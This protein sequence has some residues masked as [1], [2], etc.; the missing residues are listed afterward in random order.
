MNKVRCI[1]VAGFQIEKKNRQ[2]LWG[3]GALVAI[4][5]WS[6]AIFA[7]TS[8][9]SEQLAS[10]DPNEEIVVKV[11]FS[12]IRVAQQISK[13]YEPRESKY[14]SGFIVLQ[15]SAEEIER[16]LSI[17]DRLNVIVELD[18]TATETE[19]LKALGI[20]L[21]KK[22][23]GLLQSREQSSTLT[24]RT[25]SS[26][27]SFVGI[28]GFACYRTVEETYATAEDIVL[29]HP[30]LATWSDVG[31]S[32]EKVN[33]FGGYDLN[34]LRLTNLSIVGPK[35]TIFITSSIHAREYTTAELM[36]RFA[37]QL[38]S[39]YGVDADTTWILDH[40]DIRLMLVANPDGRKQAETGLLWRK[41]VNQNYC[42]ATSNN[43][44][45]DLNR[46][47]SF[48]WNCCNGSSTNQCSQTYHGAFAAS[49]PETQ[50]VISQLSSIFP[51]VRGPGVNDPAPLDTSGMYLDIHSS[52]R[53]IL[54]PWGFT[55]NPAP[56]GTQLQT[57]GRKLAFFNG[58]T[59]QQSIGLYPTDGT[60]TSY[61]YGELGLPSYTY[62]LGTEFFESCGYFENT[63]LPDNLPSLKYALKTV[64][65]PYLLP[66]GP[67]GYGIGLSPDAPAGV[68][69]GSIVDLTVTYDDTRYNN[70]NGAE[71]SQSIAEVEYYIDVPPWEPG[72]ETFAVAMNP[73]DGVF[74]SSIEVA[75]VSI[76]TTLLS[77][78]RHTIYT[79]ARDTAGNWGV[80][81]AAFLTID[82]NA[83]L[84]TVL[85]NDDFEND[86]G[87]VTNPNATDTATTGQW[88]RANPEQTTT[89]GGVQQLGTANSGSFNLVTGPLAGASV[90][91]ND[92]D[93]G[94]TSIRSP[95]IVIPGNATDVQ[96]SFYAYLAHTS[97]ATIDDF[98][99]VS[100][101]GSSS[102]T[103]Q[104][105]EELGS[106]D[107]DNGAWAENSV[108]LDTF[109]GET[110]YMLVEAADAGS[111]SLV[112]AGV[113]DVSISAVVLTG[114]N[115]A[116]TVEA[117][118]DQT[119]TLPAVAT[120]D[121]AV[122]DDGLPN[123][124]GAVSTTWSAVSG[125]G[126]ATFSDPSSTTT[127]VSFDVAGVYVLRLS[128]SD[129]V[130]SNFDEVVVTVSDAPPVN[131][132]PNVNAGSDLAVALPSSLILD[133]SVED[134]GL[135]NPPAS[136]TTTWSVVSGPGS[137]SFANASVVDTSATFS[138]V[139]VYVLRLSATD[140][141]LSSEDDMQVVVTSP[142]ATCPAG[143]IN[144][145]Q[146]SLESYSNQDLS[147]GASAAV[148]GSSITLTGNAWKRSTQSFD[149]TSNT[150]IKFDYASTSQGEIHG[151][152]FDL[153]QTLNND[154]RLFQFWGTQNWTGGGAINYSP[155]YGGNGAFQSYSIPV[156]NFYSGNSFRLVFVNDKDSGAANNEGI[157]QC[158]QIVEE[159]PQGSC[160]VEESF[161]GGLGGW[162]NTA[163]STCSTGAFIVGAPTE[164]NAGG[165]TTQV[166]GDHT[167]GSGLALFSA[168]NTSAGSNDIDNGVCVA[169]SPNYPVSDASDLSVWYFHGQR[170]AGD[171]PGGDFFNLELSLNGGSTWNSLV[172]NDDSTSNAAWN[173]VT[174]AI[175]AG[176]IVKMRISAADGAG[177][178][179]LVEAGLDDLEICSSP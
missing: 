12:D 163:A 31:D 17:S 156:G 55:S 50:A 86:L 41:N 178:G 93:N 79:R 138:S 21:K 1:G 78:G 132:A 61:G 114:G 66:A 4:W 121:G 7:Q 101:V 130:L 69:A 29:N 90:G 27:L 48:Q 33:G 165:V 106:S 177:P 91:S 59:P 162:A 82:N 64:R 159:V 111:G 56:N 58:H 95:D 60:T 43:R 129:S 20:G 108:S 47:F 45:A 120:L 152:G 34:V 125:P 112:E 11:Y 22:S 81:S 80:V 38:V 15:E 62:E 28:P 36:T 75:S 72:A 71:P 128:G 145:N 139:G 87:W 73:A 142:G 119:I 158:V 157:Y 127:N 52:G 98:L 70:S 16:L 39:E 54:W 30:N 42:G 164:Q 116:P 40:T 140:S 171:D 32:W 136:L 141:A 10:F 109:A 88:A 99:R 102:G 131:T 51:D 23:A 35:P 179:D 170:D 134:D 67:E 92:I 148:D 110:V 37:E 19:Q 46:N 53:L 167:T 151:I 8:I 161:S 94:M 133:G 123:P 153:D 143:S 166:G 6:N 146:L 150:V 25:Q 126:T 44:G 176:S 124:P 2:R 5:C 160:T 63:L 9:T 175:P 174:A 135:P 168:T 118:P 89:S 173:Q 117:G 26:A 149:L 122:G 113:D 74:N 14:E 96:L 57:L 144:F 147:G 155:K 154:A 105:F 84:P 103:L 76:D 100:V 104:V 65:A 115:A 137:V 97:N 18:Q 24:N 68:P 169:E 85:F 83:V 107:Q 172:S 49:E 3:L 77:E 13:T